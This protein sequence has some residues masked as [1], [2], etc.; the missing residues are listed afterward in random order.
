MYVPKSVQAV[1]T[2]ATPLEKLF[3]NKRPPAAKIL[4]LRK[5]PS[6]VNKNFHFSIQ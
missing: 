4:E 1:I 3:V 2:E 5:Y 6:N